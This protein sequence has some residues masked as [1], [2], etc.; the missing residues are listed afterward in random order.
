MII[1]SRS[2]RILHRGFPSQPAAIRR[3]IPQ[4]LFREMPAF[5]VPGCGTEMGAELFR[6]WCGVEPRHSRVSCR[7]AT[8]RH[9]VPARPAARYCA[10]PRTATMRSTSA[11]GG[12]RQHWNGAS[13]STSTAT[14]PAL[15][16]RQHK[17]CNY[18]ATA[19]AQAPARALQRHQ[20]KHG[21]LR[22]H[23]RSAAQI[24]G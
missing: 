18:T 14:T 1:S 20:H 24:T 21:S 16:R 3:E 13:T 4:F 11:A 17:H 7:V 22:R 23:F 8:D 6:V 5:D 9:F 2:A 19:P 10:C 15:E 12:L